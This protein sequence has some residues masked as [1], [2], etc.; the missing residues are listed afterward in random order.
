MFSIGNNNLFWGINYIAQLWLQ[1]I[2]WE[3]KIK[4]GSRRRI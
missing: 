1:I 2:N 3:L 4:N